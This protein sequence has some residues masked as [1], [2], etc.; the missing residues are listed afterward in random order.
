MTFVAVNGWQWIDY[1]IVNSTN[2]EAKK[3]IL[4]NSQIVVTAKKQTSGRGRMGHKWIGLDGNLFMSL[5]LNWNSNNTNILSLI[6][7][8]AILNTIKGYASNLK[9]M[10]KWPNDVLINKCKISGILIETVA[11]SKVIIGI[12]VNICASPI[13]DDTSPYCATSLKEQGIN[14][15]RIEFMQTYLKTFT[16]IMTIYQRE[17]TQKIIDLWSANTHKVGQEITIKG[18]KTQICGKFMGLDKQ[19]LLLLKTHDNDIKTISAGD[20]Y[21]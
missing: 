9:P 5:G 1:D 8:L 19:G 3:L 14:V 10:L 18:A 4:E 16:E 20:I 21:F 13:L 6:S 12:G 15:D 17:G 11:L 2:D 7:S